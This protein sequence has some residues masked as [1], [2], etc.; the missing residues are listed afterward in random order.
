MTDDQIRELLREMRDEPVPPDSKARVRMAVAQRT[1]RWPEKLRRR[2][3]MLTAVLAP[4]CLLLVMLMTREQKK[5]I[6]PAPVV[7]PPVEATVETRVPMPAPTPQP[8][9]VR[10]RRHVTKPSR[11]VV[12]GGANL[13]RIETPDPDVVILLVGG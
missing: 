10:V 7:H 6:A 8:H 9:I 2:W 4:A 11:Q 3:K 12:A 5:V 13:I 1:Q